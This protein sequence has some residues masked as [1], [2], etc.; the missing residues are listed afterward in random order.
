M[1]VESAWSYR[2][3]AR[4]RVEMGARMPSV[5][6][7]VRE[8]AW[9]AQIA[10]NCRP[11]K[12]ERPSGRAGREVVFMVKPVQDGVRHH[13]AGP[14][15]AMPLALHLHGGNAEVRVL[16]MCVVGRDCNA[17]ATTTEFVA[18]G[19]RSAESSNR[20]TSAEG[21]AFACGLRTGVVMISRSR[22][23]I[24]D[25]RR[26]SFSNNSFAMRSSPHE[27]FSCATLRIRV[28]SSGGIGGRP[29]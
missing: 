17:V 20:G 28:W 22:C 16:T 27:G 3:P 4:I 1:L 12:T 21:C 23:A 11:A 29:A 25:T 5:A 15:E 13:T 2:K 14:V 10:S 6:D 18:D 19:P 9:K 7:P 24:G 8:I 26:P